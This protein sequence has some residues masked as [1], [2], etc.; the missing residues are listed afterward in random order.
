MAELAIA[1]ATLGVIVYARYCLRLLVDDYH[2]GQRN[3]RR[4]KELE[5]ELRVRQIERDLA[6]SDDVDYYPWGP[7][8]D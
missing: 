7:L 3:Q 6:E 1:V 5:R 8:G 2:R 4:V